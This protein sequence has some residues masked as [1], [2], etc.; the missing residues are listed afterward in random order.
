MRT[1]SEIGDL[2]GLD[3]GSL[4][5][6]GAAAGKVPVAEVRDRAASRPRGKLVLITGMTPT[7]HGEGKTVTAIGLADGLQA[8][9]RR[10]TVCLRQP[11]LGPVFGVK[12]GATGGGRATVEP[13]VP[14]NLGFTGDI[15]AVAAAHNLLASLVDNHL[16]HGNAIGLDRSRVLWPRTLDIEDRALRHILTGT[17]NDPHMPPAPSS[18]VIA[19]AS[20][21][22]AILA[23]AKDYPDLKARLGRIL[24]GFDGS[25]QPIRA[26]A[27]HAE[28]SMTAILRDALEPNVVQTAEGTPAIIHAGP[29]G[30]IAHGTCSRLAIELGLAGSEYC[31]VEAGF[32]TELGAEK[33]VDIVTP[34]LGVDVDAAV[35]VVTLRGV[36]VQGGASEDDSVRPDL[37][38]TERGLVN[39]EQH[40][41]N[42]E[43]LGLVAVVALN[44]F[45]GDSPEETEVLRTVCRAHDVDV[46]ESRAFDEGGAGCRELAE[47]VRAIASLGRRS[48]P[49]NAAGTEPQEQ[50]RSIVTRLYGGAGIEETPEALRDLEE[51]SRIAET[52]GP[53]CVA[54]TQLSL[55]DDPH[56]FG[57]PQGFVSPVHRYTRSAGAGF[58]VA[59]LG[60]IE[61]MPGLPTH[62]A[63][64]RIDVS[65][66]GHIVGLV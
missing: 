51:L 11:S 2:L 52:A 55:S 34:V 39:V 25:A 42:L 54:K 35:L 5:P 49:L 29:F 38:A 31:V 4:R 17:G 61:T 21:V 30:N 36:R 56:R 63:A 44:R 14:I 62:P 37:P 26:S 6:A 1:L 13:S 15:H 16:Y 40:L 33:F 46:V 53:I 9:G 23:L 60:S 7:R 45:P 22:M 64:E 18:F 59:Y 10:A 27:L 32:S 8:I 41:A 43:A 58:T 12:G 66:D 28:G 57:R 20:E 19:A 24:V 48:H 65:P 50:L 47:A 3:P